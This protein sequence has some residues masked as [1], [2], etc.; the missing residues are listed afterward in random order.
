MTHIFINTIYSI[1]LFLLF[2]IYFGVTGFSS[3]SSYV[4]KR[5]RLIG[6]CVCVQTRLDAHYQARLCLVVE[7]SQVTWSIGY[8]IILGWLLLC[9]S[10]GRSLGWGCLREIQ[11]LCK[12][13]CMCPTGMGR[14]CKTLRL[15][16]AN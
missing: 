13:V 9:I 1:I 14:N 3:L 4:G 7:S 16:M 15:G 10:Y 12:C 11:I 5:C 2:Y 6:W 8:E